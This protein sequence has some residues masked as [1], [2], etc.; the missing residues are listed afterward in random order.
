M[1]QEAL[2][3]LIAAMSAL[4]ASLRK[5]LNL[6]GQWKNPDWPKNM[7]KALKDL[8]SAIETARDARSELQGRVIKFRKDND[9]KIDDAAAEQL[10]QLDA[11][12]EAA[13]EEIERVETVLR[14]N[15]SIED[16]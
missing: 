4:D 6:L 8:Q 2:D 13:G 3:A 7:K 15:P 10:R 16:A 14:D 11:A 12:V 5:Y 1:L 9:G